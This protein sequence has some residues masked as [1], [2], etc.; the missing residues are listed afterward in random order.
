VRADPSIRAMKKPKKSHIPKPK[1]KAKMKTSN[2]LK[3]AK[4]IAA[5]A[6][7]P[8]SI[9]TGRRKGGDS[10]L[11]LYVRFPSAEI[12]AKVKMMADKTEASMNAY[13]VAATLAWVEDGKTLEKPEATPATK[14]S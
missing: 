10:H 7:K 6:K 3:P 2:K 4:R 13:I 1:A 9:A 14:A 8:V 12:K 5:A 11:G